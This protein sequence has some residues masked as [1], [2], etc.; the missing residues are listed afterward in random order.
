MADVNMKMV[1]INMLANFYNST[2]PF[3]TEKM[4][5]YAEL[6]RESLKQ[7]INDL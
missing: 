7:K 3:Y 2:H 5:D 4:N 1:E 6:L